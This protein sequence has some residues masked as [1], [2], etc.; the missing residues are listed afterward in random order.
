MSLN[1]AFDKE[2]ARRNLWE[3]TLSDENHN[4][5][6]WTTGLIK[7]IN[8]PKLA[9]TVEDIFAG[10]SK[11]YTGWKLPDNLQVTIWETSNHDVEKYL[12]SWMMGEKG[13]FNPNSGAFRVHL[14]EDYLY[15]DVRIKTLRYKY[16]SS[17]PYKV[18]KQDVISALYLRTKEKLEEQIGVVTATQ[19]EY[20]HELTVKTVNEMGEFSSDG[21]MLFVT[22]ET[23]MQKIV[24]IEKK[25]VIP[26]LDKL[27]AAVSGLANQAVAR[28]PLL[29]SDITR[30][31]IPPV[32]IPPP[33]M[34]IPVPTGTPMP[35]PPMIMS[36]PVQL[37]DHISELKIEAPI[38]L[39][40]ESIK[41]NIK[42]TI[43]KEAKK[44]LIELA[45]GE[46]TKAK[47]WK[48]SE[49]ETSL[50]TYSTAIESY[51][52]GTYDY[53]TGEGVSYTVNLAVRDIKIKGIS[54]SSGSGN[55]E[56]NIAVSARSK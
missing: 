47:R 7:S 23:P 56:R 35:Q 13:I 49:V 38:N 1:A 55:A 33:L 42:G 25:Q 21:N 46:A 52:I 28:V 39:T 53:A 15:R 14:E 34:R 54:D 10:A 12:D 22:Q 45:G 30:R 3:A 18:Y 5:L 19:R 8:I 26:V 17:E 43:S 11:G 31:L 36:K 2:F 4:P 40:K 32:I 51:D 29:E 24:M 44:V 6:S 48:A 37:H 20:I 9:F 27:T 16:E 50:I 41:S